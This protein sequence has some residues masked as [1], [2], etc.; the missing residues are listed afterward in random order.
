VTELDPES[1]PDPDP[2]PDL[3]PFFSGFMDA[4]KIRFF[5]F[6]LITYA[7]AHYLLS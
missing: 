7:Q 5:L 2:T 6:F 3:T 4:K 1:D